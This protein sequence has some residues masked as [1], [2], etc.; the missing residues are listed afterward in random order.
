MNETKEH[1][2]TLRGLSKTKKNRM[3]QL[4]TKHR[5]SLNSEILNA[6]DFYLL[7]FN[8]TA[9]QIAKQKGESSI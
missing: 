3:K 1:R 4:V 7:N 8:P 9:E 5:T 2:T 6:I